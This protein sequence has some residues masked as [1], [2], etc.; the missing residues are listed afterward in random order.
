MKILILYFSG[1]GNTQKIAELYSKAFKECGDEVITETLPDAENKISALNLNEFDLIGFGYPI[2]AFNAP[3]NVLKLAEKIPLLKEQ[4]NAFVF[5]T[6]GEPVRMS[7]VS[8]LKLI[9]ILKK[10]N[11]SVTNEYQYVMPYNIIFRHSDEMAYRMW[12]VAQKIVP[13]DCR[14]IKN[15]V[16]KK[17]K[18]MFMGGFLAW[19]LRI[20]HW[21]AR[22]NGKRYK[23][24]SDCVHCGLCA[25][26]CPANNITLAPDGKIKFG[27]N[28][29]MCMRCS[30]TCPKNAIKIG[31]FNSWKVNGAYSFAPPP[32]DAPNPPDKHADYCKKAYNR[33][34][35]EAEQK[36]NAERNEAN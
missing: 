2:H 3:A 34:F 27:K 16:P 17:A 25:R 20:E 14:E 6:S 36:I 5:K 33:Y 29:L 19:F 10:R 21:G 32:A 15:G 8:S 26:T 18:R 22:F 24:S 9:K 35:S 13:L 31:L 12:D 1:T 11:I 28:C 23:V 4:K 7:D 30:F